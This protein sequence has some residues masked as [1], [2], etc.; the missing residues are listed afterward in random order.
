MKFLHLT[1]PHLVARAQ[2]LF[3]IDVKARLQQ[4][5]ESMNAR[6]GD[7]ELC[8]LTG[9]LAHWAEPEAYA[10]VKA[11]M[12]G[13]K[14]PWY[15][16]LGNH[17]DREIFRAIFPDAADDGNGFLQYSIE[18]AAGRFILL[19]TLKSRRSSRAPHRRRASC[20]SAPPGRACRPK[21]TRTARSTSATSSRAGW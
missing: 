21:A 1:D 15:P 8:V 14:M 6:H 18:T 13:L 5:V 4:A 2:K 20:S 17:D 11:I 3:D 7:G 16:I 19:D 9:D 10:D 12:D